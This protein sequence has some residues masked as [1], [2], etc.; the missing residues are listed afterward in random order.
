MYTLVFKQIFIY[1][2]SSGYQAVRQDL[3]VQPLK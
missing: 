1:F 2:R 3:I